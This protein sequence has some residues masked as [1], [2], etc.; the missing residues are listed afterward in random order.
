MKNRKY[1]YFILIL[2]FILTLLRCL[3]GLEEVS[4]GKIYM[5]DV[6]I[7]NQDARKRGIGMV[8]QQ[9]SLF[10]NMTVEQN[11]AFRPE[12]VAIAREKT[13][14]QS[15]NIT[16]GTIK[17]VTLHGNFIRYSVE[18][19]KKKI[20]VDQLFDEVFPFQAGDKVYLSIKEQDFIYLSE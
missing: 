6:D 15:E 9:Y 2:P 12:A 18:V 10:P 5:D 11:I 7:T 14:L 3:A 17:E 8:F 16:F 20:D 19:G 4:D 13:L 1:F